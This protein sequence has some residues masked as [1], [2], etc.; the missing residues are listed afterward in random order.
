[1]STDG[2]LFARAMMSIRAI[3]MEQATR[4]RGSSLSDRIERQSALRWRGS[5]TLCRFGSLLE[6]IGRY[7]QQYRVR[8]PLPVRGKAT[9]SG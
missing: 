5:R 2:I 4:H 8:R 3:E 1:M 6:R 7:L 9:Q